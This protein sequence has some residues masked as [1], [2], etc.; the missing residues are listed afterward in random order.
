[1]AVQSKLMEAAIKCSCQEY[2]HPWTSSCASGSAGIILSALPYSLR[3][4]TMVYLLALLLRRRIPTLQDLKRT[5]IGILKSSAFLTTNTFGVNFFICLMRLLL[6]RF[7]FWTIAYIPAFIASF[8]ALLIERPERR[9]SLTLYVANVS[10]ESLWKMLEA[11]GIV[12]S[13]PNGQVL[14][15]GCS[16]T[17]L[18]YMYRLGIHKTKLKDSAFKAIQLLIGK[19]EEGPIESS[20]AAAT[21]QSSL[22]QPLNLRKISAYIQIYT[23]LLSIKHSSCPHRKGCSSHVLMGGLKPFIGGVGAQVGLKLL[24]NLRKIF[25]LKLDWRKQIFNKQNL[26][27]GLALGSFSLSYKLISCALRHICGYDSAFFAIPAGLLGSIGLLHFPN[28]TIALYVM[29]RTLQLL[30]NWGRGEGVLPKI[31]YFVIMLY[32]A[33]TALIFH[34]AIVEPKSLRS[35][36]YKF[37][38][39]ISGERI[40]RFNVSPFDAYGFGTQSQADSVIKK[41][42]IDLSHKLP[43]IPLVV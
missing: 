3:T 30:Y 35:S 38:S 33:C 43:K 6:G 11:R 13:I 21:T 15:L 18:L 19:E 2:L 39:D 1:M 42:G 12:R 23:H 41:L 7:Y 28:T 29:W 36:Y 16:V 31:P 25:K 4:Y 9:T 20:T 40:C 32:S 10:T 24:L 22:E 5:I 8:F 37:G 27:L 26:S 17:A 34:S 14:V